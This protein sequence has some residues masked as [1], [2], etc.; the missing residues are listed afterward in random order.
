MKDHPMIFN[1]EMVRAILE[2][3]KTQTRRLIKIGKEWGDTAEE[4]SIIKINELDSSVDPHWIVFHNEYPEEGGSVPFKCPFGKIGDRLWVRE[5]WADVNT[6][7]G[8]ALMFKDGS[9]HFCVDDAYPVEYSRYPNCNFTMW[10]GDLARGEDGHA[11]RPSIHMP[12]WASRITLEIT[13][14]R[15]ERLQD[16][17]EEDAIAEGIV[18]GYLENGTSGFG[19]NENMPDIYKAKWKF[20][21]LWNSIYKNWDA[22]PF[23]WAITFKRVEG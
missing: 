18:G 23:V 14:V 6:D 4:F 11:W 12:R 13:D 17:S 2:G 5:T 7:N 8:P 21:S 20:K 1:G 15:Y 10:C 19:S 9:F 3:R 16:I 22:N